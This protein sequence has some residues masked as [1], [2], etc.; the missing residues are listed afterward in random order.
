MILNAIS[1]VL[2]TAAFFTL[3]I[4]G[5]GA[6]DYPPARQ[7]SWIAKDFKF[8][9]GEVMPEL[10]INYTT[11]G[12]PKG[13]PVLILHGTTGSGAGMLTPGFAGELFGAGQPL[14]ATKYFI[15]LPDAIGTG[16]TSKPSDGLRAKFPRYNYD[17]M[18][19]AQHRLVTEGLGLQHLRLYPGNT[20]LPPNSTLNFEPGR[21]RANS[22]VVLL[23]AWYLSFPWI[24]WNAVNDVHPVTLAIP[25]LLW[26]VWFLDTDRLGAFAIMGVLVLMTGELVGLTV[27]MLGVWYAVR[28]RRVRVGLGIAVVGASWT[29]FCLFVLIP[30]LNNGAPSRFYNRFETVGGSPEG[31]A[32]TLVTDPTVVLSAISAEADLRYLLLVLLPTGFLA[33]GSPLLAAAALPQLGVN[34]MSDFRSTTSPAY[35]YVAPLT[36]IFIAATVL[37][38]ARFPERLR[39]VCAGA[40]LTC[41]L[42]VL[43][44]VPPTPGREPFAFAPRDTPARVA[45]MREALALIPPHAPLTATN[46]LGAHLSG[47]RVSHLFPDDARAEWAVVDTRDAWLASAGEQTKPIRFRRLLERLDRESSWRL[48]FEEEGIRVYRRSGSSTAFVTPSIASYEAVKDPG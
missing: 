31:L 36:A 24:M 30:S 39:V 9:S 44:S 27:A 13:E 25:L 46:R 10:R 3:S 33:L 28:Y 22:A 34:L 29:A 45:A 8:A 20:I 11:V 41:A 2:L 18:V 19:A 5:A 4:A 21:T 14:D 37:A 48:V 15:I 40:A 17:D 1:R 38:I 23:G 26:A 47:R 6:A 43:A 42:V 35:Q 16:K 32:R 12:D 7:G